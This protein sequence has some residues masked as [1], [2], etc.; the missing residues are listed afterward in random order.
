MV[1]MSNKGYISVKDAR[2]DR[3]ECLIIELTERLDAITASITTLNNRMSGWRTSDL[4]PRLTPKPVSTPVLWSIPP[5]VTVTQVYK[6]DPKPP[7][8]GKLG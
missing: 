4:S 2:M 7:H 6:P 3:L 5:P 8:G 1:V